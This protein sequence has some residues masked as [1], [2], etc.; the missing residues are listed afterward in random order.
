SKAIGGSG[1]QR[2]TVKELT[3]WVN[4]E[5]ELEGDD[6]YAERTVCGWLH[7]LG[8]NVETVRKRLY[9]DGHERPDVVADRERFGQE[10]DKVKPLLLTIDDESLE[11]EPNPNARYILVSQD[12]KIHHSNDVQKRYWSN[13]EF[14]APFHKGSGR[15]VMTS[16]FM[17]EIFGFIKYSEDDDVV[18]GERVGSV[19]DVSTDGYYENAQ[20][21]CDFA[22]CSEAVGTLGKGDLKCIFLT[23]NSPIHCK[24]AEDA[25][26]IKA[27]NVKPGGQQPRMRPGWY[28]KGKKKINQPM[29]FPA[30]HPVYPGQPKGLRQVVRER[31]GEDACRG[32]K[33]EGLV[34]LLSACEDFRSQKTLLQEEAEARGDKVIYG[35]KFHPELAP[36]E[37]AYRSIA[38]RIRVSNT[39]GSSAGFKERVEN[40][41]D[42]SGLT[43]QLMRKFF[44]SSREYL[45]HYREGKSMKE[46]ESLRSQK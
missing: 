44:R 26:N 16:D 2:L 21:R 43:L 14:T 19:L 39:A 13:G 46:I 1:K 36:I 7:F 6:K 45:R 34:Q 29:V 9:V 23:D 24:M 8:Y 38:E 28:W 15:T 4:R 12:E 18:P 11:I 17:S 30:S 10:L 40:V 20:C 32:L 5:L 37:A 41:Q 27:M 22:E 42:E 31:F 33:H 3:S 25:L 35:V